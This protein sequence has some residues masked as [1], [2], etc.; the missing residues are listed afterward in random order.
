[1]VAGGLQVT[2]ALDGL[3]GLDER[4]AEHVK[5]VSVMGIADRPIAEVTNG[6]GEITAEKCQ[7][8]AVILEDRVIVRAVREDRLDGLGITP[9]KSNAGENR[10][11]VGV[12]C[13]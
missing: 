13:R 4:I 5:P 9:V 2:L 12:G 8:T 7:P 6:R 11:G 10:P 1:M 3:P